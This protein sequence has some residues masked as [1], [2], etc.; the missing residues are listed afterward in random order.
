MLNKS[1]K[2]AVVTVRMDNDLKRETE[3]LL[4]DMGLT[5]SGAVNLLARAIVNE[6]KIPFEIKA[7]PFY[8]AAN[9]QALSANCRNNIAMD[10]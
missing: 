9:Q 6:R 3:A 2:K 8:G 4:G 5:F 7:D 10:R 1:T